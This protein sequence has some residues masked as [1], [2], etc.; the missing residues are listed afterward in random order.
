[1]LSADNMTT[2]V[3]CAFYRERRCADKHLVRPKLRVRDA[4]MD[5]SFARAGVGPVAAHL[6]QIPARQPRCE[7]ACTRN[8]D[9]NART[10]R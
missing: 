5:N 1:M 2:R 7:L 10:A 6:Q 9:S 3:Y 4:G 8:P